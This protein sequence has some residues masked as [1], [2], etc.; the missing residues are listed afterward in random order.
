MTKK[1]SK[2]ARL[3]SSERSHR[4]GETGHYFSVSLDDQE[5]APPEERTNDHHN[6]DSLETELAKIMDPGEPA[7]DPE[8]L[9]MIFR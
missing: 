1:K 6:F 9:D 2:K 7:G 8:P 5:G 4:A 3:P